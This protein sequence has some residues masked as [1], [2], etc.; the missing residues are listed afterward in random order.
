MPG[1]T[2]AVTGAYRLQPAWLSDTSRKER[3]KVVVFNTLGLTQNAMPSPRPSAPTTCRCG[4]ASYCAGL[5]ARP[6]ELPGNHGWKE[7]ARSTQS[8]RAA[9]GLDH[10]PPCEGRAEQGRKVV[11]VPRCSGACGVSCVRAGRSR[12]EAEK[13][14]RSSGLQRRL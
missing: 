14:R 7:E 9:R 6:S 4:T 12:K 13:L 3:R 2:N 8:A 11:S 5:T 1:A 10:L